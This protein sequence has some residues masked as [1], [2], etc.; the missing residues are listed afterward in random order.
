[1]ESVP[2]NFCGANQPE[3]QYDLVDWMTG[4]AQQ[5]TLVRCGAC[6]LR[7]LNPRPTSSELPAFYPELYAPYHVPAAD[8]LLGKIRSGFQQM[9][10]QRRSGWI[11]RYSGLKREEVSWT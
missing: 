11:R 3:K 8:T 4:S 1:M 2:C 5:F 7:Y 6:G 10:W 9:V